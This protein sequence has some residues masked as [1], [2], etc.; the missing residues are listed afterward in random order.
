MKLDKILQLHAD[1]KHHQI[2]YP[3]D[4]GARVVEDYEADVASRT[5]WLED[6]AEGL[7]LAMQ[8]HEERTFPW[9]GASGVKYPLITNACNQ[10][11]ARAYPA[12]V[13]GDKIVSF[14]R[15]PKPPTMQPEPAPL[16]AQTPAL[17]GGEMPAMGQPMPGGPAQPG[18]QPG[19][20]EGGMPTT[21]PPQPVEKPDM[22]EMYINALEEDLNFQ[23]MRETTEWEDEQDRNMMILPLIGSTIKKTYPDPITRKVRSVVCRPDNIVFNYW[24]KSLETAK[25]ITHVLWYSE[26][27]FI[28]LTRAGYFDETA[29]VNTSGDQRHED[30]FAEASDEAK[31]LEKPIE[32]DV[33]VLEQH[34]WEDLDGDG[35]AEP[36]I[37]WVHEGQVLRVEPRF[38]T[39]YTRLPDGEILDAAL[40]DIPGT[41]VVR[42]EPVEF[43]TL[44]TF[45]PSPDGSILGLG[46]GKLLG[47]HNEAV[48]SLINQLV[49]AGTLSNVQGGLLA[50]NVRT[51]SGTIEIVPGVF[52]KTEAN[53]NDLKNGVMP[54]PIKEPSNVLFSLLGLLIDAGEKISS[55]SKAMQG[56]NP[57]QNQPAT[58]SM[59]VLEQGLQVFSAIFKRTY[60][61]MTCELRKYV[62]WNKQ[63]RPGWDEAPE[64]VMP[65]ADPN[66]VSPQQRI[67]KAQ[68][69]LMRTDARPHFYGL[70]GQIEAEKRFLDALQ[71]E[72]IDAL[73]SNPQEP[74][75]A[76]EMLEHE[77][78]QQL[79]QAR[80]KLDE[81]CTLSNIE[82]DKMAT[83]T[84]GM[85]AEDNR[86]KVMLQQSAQRFDQLAKTAELT[87][88]E[89]ELNVK[90]K[91]STRRF[92]GG[93]EKSRGDK[94]SQNDSRS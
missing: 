64:L 72:G 47:P 76:P 54:W 83:M 45:L 5:S 25:T 93:L 7:K 21:A 88:Q 32:G 26:N 6:N 4:L 3:D 44:Y 75:P 33:C 8:V 20:A 50:R 70:Q 63:N 74:P 46:L 24:A 53:A 30:S 12:L 69:L 42:I 86:M 28:G 39:V 60:R 92:V 51:K 23:I 73:L 16:P 52:H 59:A 22:K 80:L 43:F 55:V 36:Y 18:M 78:N 89:R 41:K 62:Y 35:Y 15:K 57:G 94:A 14:V 82:K 85:N 81:Q 87:L 61:S 77:A 19:G 68:A 90:D 56:Q 34:R 48:N 67:G 31:G 65:V 11:N 91:D 58:T 66:V 37:V 40:M 84:K 13:P 79:E 1:N 29:V 10:F 49:D 17:P 9:P 38:K 2:K 27:E 71:I